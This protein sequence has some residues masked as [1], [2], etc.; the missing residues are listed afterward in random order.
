MARKVVNDED[1]KRT[2]PAVYRKYLT[3]LKDV[4]PAL[5][6]MEKCAENKLMEKEREYFK[7]HKKLSVQCVDPTIEYKKRVYVYYQRKI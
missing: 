4:R 2:K 5:Q 7:T 3:L 1:A 6:V